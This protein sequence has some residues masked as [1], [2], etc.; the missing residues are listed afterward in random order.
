MKFLHILVVI[1]MAAQIQGVHCHKSH[2]HRISSQMHLNAIEYIIVC[3][4]SQRLEL[5]KMKKEKTTISKT[6]EKKIAMENVKNRRKWHY[7]DLFLL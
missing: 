3:E 7:Y 1:F 5:Q 4:R 6:T 2:R